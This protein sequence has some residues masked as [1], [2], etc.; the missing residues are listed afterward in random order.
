MRPKD[1]SR[2]VSLAIQRFQVDHVLQRVFDL[3]S[4]EGTAAPIG[5]CFS[6][7]QDFVQQAGDQLTVRRRVLQTDQTRRDL[8]VEQ[9]LRSLADGLQ[10]EAKFLSSGVHDRRMVAFA[11][12]LPKGRDVPDFTRV[13]HRQLVADGHLDQ[14]QVGAIG[15]FRDEFRVKSDKR[16]IAQSADRIPAVVQQMDRLVLHERFD[17]RAGW[18]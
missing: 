13:N 4:R 1:S 8:R 17:I 12:R 16:S 11:E 3:A 7:G 18:R 14:A 10:A 15:V 9:P 2:A 5:S 6:L